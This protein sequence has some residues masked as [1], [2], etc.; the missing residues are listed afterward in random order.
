MSPQT[1]QPLQEHVGGGDTGNEKVRINIQGL[2]QHYEKNYEDA[3]RRMADLTTER[4]SLK[5]AGE[6]K[7][8]ALSQARGELKQKLEEAAQDRKKV[9]DDLQQRYA[10][11]EKMYNTAREDLKNFQGKYDK[12]QAD[13]KTE[14]TKLQQNVKTWREQYDKLRA[15]EKGEKPREET[16]T[17]DGK[18][19]KVEPFHEFVVLSGGE[20]RN[21]QR[22]GKFIIYTESPGGA[23]EPKGKVVVSE[24]GDVTSIATIL[25]QDKRITEGDLFVGQETWDKFQAQGAKVAE[26]PAAVA[27]PVRPAAPVKAAPAA[28]AA[29]EGAAAAPAA[30][31][32]AAAEPAAPAKAAPAKEA[33]GGAESFFGETAT[34]EKPKK[35]K[36]K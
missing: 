7:D 19:L 2:L 33:E 31:A 22:N 32:P 26:A 20:N 36:N 17:A 11:L 21:R 3:K 23:R 8:L 30:S 24:V 16:M 12:D 5:K 9:V 28:P 4:D 18:V 15:E 1:P 10:E 29:A 27:A 35:A 13:W 34:P 6:D 14:A 25:N